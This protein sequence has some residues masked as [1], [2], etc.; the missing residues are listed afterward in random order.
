MP[1]QDAE[2]ILYDG[3]CAVC[4]TFGSLAA[5]N[6]PADYKLLPFQSADLEGLSPGLTPEMVDRAMVLVHPDRQR[7]G[8]ARA[9][10]TVMREMRGLW[11][12]LGRLLLPLSPLFEPFYQLF[13]RYRHLAAPLF[14]RWDPGADD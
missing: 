12:L 4:R 9:V 2:T 11:G 6:L 10:L 8:G 14:A 5:R 1:D 7:V 13:A 3:D